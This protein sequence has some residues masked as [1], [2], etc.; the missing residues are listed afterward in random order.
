M[1]L[2]SNLGCSGASH[3]ISVFHHH[4]GESEDGVGDDEYDDGND[5]NFLRSIEKAM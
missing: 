3:E 5:K 4:D 2:G 1:S